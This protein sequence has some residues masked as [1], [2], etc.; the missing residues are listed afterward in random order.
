MPTL[1]SNKFSYNDMTVRLG[2]QVLFD[3]TGLEVEFG[4]EHEEVRGK[5]GKAQAINEKNFGVSGTLSMLQGDFEAIVEQYGTG[6]QKKYFQITWNFQDDNGSLKTHIIVGL[7]LG[8]TK[9]AL[10]NGDAFMQ[11]DIPFLALDIK[12]NQ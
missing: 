7:K 8:K 12:L 10:K 3:A 4:Y 5:G 2:G 11:I 9:L 1:N 6:Y